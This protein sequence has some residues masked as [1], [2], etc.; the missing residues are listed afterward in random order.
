MLK[1][2]K[3]ISKFHKKIERSQDLFFVCMS[4]YSRSCL[5]FL[6]TVQVSKCADVLIPSPPKGGL[7]LFWL[8]TSS[9]I[10]LLSFPFFSYTGRPKN[11]WLTELDPVGATVRYEV[12]KLC[13]YSA[14]AMVG[15]EVVLSQYQV[16]PVAN[17][18]HC[19]STYILIKFGLV[20]SNEY[21]FG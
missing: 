16:V 17:W 14:A 9:L 8:V 7:S 12:M 10:S 13:Q 20:W 1:W 6:R 3:R 11:Q 19:V 15:T 5:S 18:W 4:V 21:I 2:V